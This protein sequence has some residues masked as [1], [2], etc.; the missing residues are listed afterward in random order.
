MI[1]FKSYLKIKYKSFIQLIFK[2]FYGS[3]K[4]ASLDEIKTVLTVKNTE[5]KK[6]FYKTYR[7]KN[8][9]LFTTSVHDQSVIVN[10][11]LIE[12]PSFQLRVKKNDKL[13]ARNNGNIKENIALKIGT[14][15]I[16]K[17]LKGKVFSLLSGGAAKTNYYHW[18]F[19]ILPKLEILSA[20]EKIENI[21][22]FLLPSTK[23][24]HQLET[25]NLLN[26]PRKKLLDS[27]SFKH[28]TCEDLYVV[29][30]PFRLTNN[31]AHD[32]QNI[33]FWI[34]EWLRKNF[35]KFKSSKSFGD[36]IFIDRS[37]SI[38]TYRDIKNKDEVYKIFKDNDFNFI[39]PENFGFRDQI[40]IFF[41][42]KKIAGLHGAAF[43]NICFCSPKTQIIEFKT[44][45]TGMNSGNIALKNNL[46]YKG[47]ICEAINKIG[48][49]QGKLIVPI[50]ELKKNIL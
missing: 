34:F 21:D 33:P 19:E 47:I 16:L 6:S 31:T 39:R 36:K 44:A 26:I 45:G 17:K 28:I 1:P 18:L 23:M 2:Y 4:I 9:R 50:E 46:D 30:H 35:L 15:R 32:T 37:K 24:D 29:D 41:S 40:S 10:N 22:Y 27:N 5:I 7:L 8:C 13:F 48:G 11:K 20:T 25:F 3:V 42:A 49:Q 38:S 14:P 12:G 43:A